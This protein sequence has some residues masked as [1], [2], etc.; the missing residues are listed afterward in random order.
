MAKHPVSVTF[1]NPLEHPEML[2]DKVTKELAPTGKKVS[3]T[4]RFSLVPHDEE[5]RS[6]YE[7]EPGEE[8]EIP[9]ELAYAIAGLAPQLVRGAAPKAGAAAAQ[10]TQQKKQ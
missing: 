3:H 5:S 10:P 9:G 6:D 1:H 8:V 2:F 4:L 7:V